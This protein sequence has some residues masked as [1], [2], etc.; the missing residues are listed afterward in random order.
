M[1]DRC[2][3]FVPHKSCVF[4]FKAQKQCSSSV[5]LSVATS[6]SQQG[7]KFDGTCDLTG[8][9]LTRNEM[10][11]ATLHRPIYG[12]VGGWVYFF[13]ELQHNA[14]NQGNCTTRSQHV[15]AC[16]ARAHRGRRRLHN[17]ALLSCIF[18]RYLWDLSGLTYVGPRC[19][20][21]GKS[22]GIS[23]IYLCFCTAVH[24]LK[25]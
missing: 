22:F 2:A 25:G 18:C 21:G 15:T 7:E 12:L 8:K 17:S 11:N 4:F 13:P 20:L 16:T 23:V 1:R 14:R 10:T 24:D 19:R 3:S 6:T 9:K 5:D